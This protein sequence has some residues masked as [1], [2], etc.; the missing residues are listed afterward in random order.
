MYWFSS[1]LDGLILT[2]NSQFINL[3]STLIDVEQYKCSNVNERANKLCRDA[4]RAGRGCLYKNSKF[5][6]VLFCAIS[7]MVNYHILSL[8]HYSNEIT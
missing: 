6:Y 2:L 1:Q 3:I 7:I 4:I 8:K 5:I